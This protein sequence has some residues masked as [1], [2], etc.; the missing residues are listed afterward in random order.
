MRR[1]RKPPSGGGD[2]DFAAR[3]GLSAAEQDVFWTPPADPAVLA[4]SASPGFLAS[5][6]ALRLS[7]PDRARNS[8]EGLH[9]ILR[10]PGST[11]VVL[12]K[13][14]AGDRPLAA[15][16]PL[17]DDLPRRVEALL[18][19]WRVWRGL[20]APPDTRMTPLQRRRLRSM[21]QAS[22]GRGRGASYREIATALYDPERVALEPWKTSSLRDAVIGL[23]RGGAAMIDGGYLQLLRHRRR[24]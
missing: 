18:R 5:A 24:R 17:D 22:D 23:V 11:Q 3:P 4:L 12:L 20:P 7:L 1:C 19:F 21:L 2:C 8:D 6:S 10:T 15:L 13:G 14:V 9:A 16:V